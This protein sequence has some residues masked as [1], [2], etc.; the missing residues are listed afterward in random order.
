MTTVVVSS[1]MGPFLF[2]LA[3]VY[4]GGYRADF[5]FSA[6]AAGAI[7]FVSLRADNPQR[8]KGSPEASARVVAVRLFGTFEV[9]AKAARYE[10]DALFTNWVKSRKFGCSALPRRL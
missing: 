1:A 8:R 4:L 9:L 5:A 7:A 10:P 6:L 3:E 2:S